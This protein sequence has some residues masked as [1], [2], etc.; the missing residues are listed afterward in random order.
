[1]KLEDAALLNVPNDNDITN[2]LIIADN[3]AVKLYQTLTY[4]H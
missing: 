1:M 4:F 3:Y 2:C